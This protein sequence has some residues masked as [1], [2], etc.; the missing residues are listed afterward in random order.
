MIAEIMGLLIFLG[1][2][3]LLFARY[4]GGKGGNNA[5]GNALKV[6]MESLKNEMERT[7]EQAIERMGGHVN[8][9]DRLMKDAKILD[10][11]LSY[12][13]KEVRAVEDRLRKEMSESRAM[14]EEIK[15]ELERAKDLRDELQRQAALTSQLINANIENPLINVTARRAVNS[16][17]DMSVASEEIDAPLIEA[18]KN[19][20]DFAAL[21][22][23]SIEKAEEEERASFEPLRETYEPSDEAAELLKKDKTEK[24]DKPKNPS[25]T[26]KELLTQ[27]ASVEEVMRQTGMGRGAVELLKGLLERK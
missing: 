14:S 24:E 26:A 23:E 20:G 2:A 22:N 18:P 11:D 1:A 21:L 12:R 3:L 4:Q 10:E 5:D 9:F 13:V 8:R 25:D 19:K 17:E 6:S 16:Y 7:S 15:R 27:G